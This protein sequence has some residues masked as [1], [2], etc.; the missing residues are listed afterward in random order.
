MTSSWTR[1]VWRVGL[2]TLFLAGCFPR[3]PGKDSGPPFWFPYIQGEGP[4]TDLW[5][6]AVPGGQRRRLT[7][8]QLQESAPTVLADGRI[9]FASKETG[10]WQL[11]VVDPRPAAPQEST[12]LYPGGHGDDFTPVVSPSGQVI[13]VSNRTGRNQLYAIVPGQQEATLLTPAAGIFD[14]PA[15]GP[16]GRIAYVRHFDGSRQIWL[17]DGDGGQPTQL[18]DLD[19]DV[20]NLSL[21]PVSDLTP[22]YR[23]DQALLLP[24]APPG[25]A[26]QQVLRNQILF[27]AHR[28]SDQRTFGASRGRDL[29]IYRYDPATARVLNLTNLAGN[30]QDP[31]VLPSGMIAFTTDRSGTREIWTMDSWGG[32]QTPW[33]TAKPWVSTR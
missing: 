32:A 22:P 28:R 2:I 11:K 10:R 9:V 3:V 17:M 1:T 6:V 31:V 24:S 26:Y 33:I 14:N 12:F 21:L 13:F 19:L 4:D 18:T 8:D 20:T 7:N 30:D 27:V 16:D 5:A 25:Q 23:L 29:D 15:P